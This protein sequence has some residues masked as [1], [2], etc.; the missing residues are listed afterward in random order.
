MDTP[1]L[2]IH[3]AKGG[4]NK[5]KTPTEA[6]DSLRSVAVAKMLLAV[7]EGKFEGTPTARDIYLDNTPLADPAGNL[8]FPN[9]RWEWRTGSVEQG[10]IPGIPS[11]ENEI[12]ESVELRS[13]N[14]Y[15]TSDT[16]LMTRLAGVALE[17]IFRTGYRYSKAEVLLMDL[18]QPGEFSE[19][20]FAAR[21]S[22]ASDRLMQVMDDINGRWGRGTM[23]AAGVP[24]AP[25]WGMRRDMMSQ[26]FTTKLD[27]LWTVRC[28]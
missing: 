3:G 15:P 7:G 18:R 24:V 2:D 13:D 1:Q 16:L 12:S 9:V 20:L 6:P 19:D 21:Q 14:A 27:Q 4:S 11:I 26:S 23:R 10:H 5:P 8:N 22:A 28:N 25:D 17:Q